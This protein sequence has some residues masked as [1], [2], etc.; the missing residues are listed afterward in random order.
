MA[1]VLSKRTGELFQIRYGAGLLDQWQRTCPAALARAVSANVA[2]VL[3]IAV[4][5]ACGCGERSNGPDKVAVNTQ[6]AAEI[7]ARN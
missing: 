2:A 7:M 3:S 4:I 6:H 5:L 1:D